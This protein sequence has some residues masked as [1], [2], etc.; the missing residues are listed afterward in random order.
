MISDTVRT[1]IFI[2]DIVAAHA[3]NLVATTNRTIWRALEEELGVDMAEI[4][5]LL[6]NDPR[7]AYD[8][9]THAVKTRFGPNAELYVEEMPNSD[10]YRHAR[11][12]ISS[13][14]AGSIV[15]T[16]LWSREIVLPRVS[17]PVTPPT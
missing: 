11:L 2:N 13:D 3:R 17:F 1:M 7:A 15:C 6:V 8:A 4:E 10:T 16:R 12:V 5:R 14:P 9:V